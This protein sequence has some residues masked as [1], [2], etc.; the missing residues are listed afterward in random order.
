MDISPEQFSELL[1]TLKSISPMT[2]HYTITGAA[3][4]PGIA[5]VFGLVLTGGGVF[6]AVIAYMWKDLKDTIREDRA[7]LRQ[8]LNQHIEEDKADHDDIW[9][10]IHRCQGDCCPR[11]KT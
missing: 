2:Q 1:V 10:E 3:D 11:G 5:A 4:W 7:D 9:E 6:L 8:R